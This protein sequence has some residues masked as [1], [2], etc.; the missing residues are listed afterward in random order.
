MSFDAF[1][2]AWKALKSTIQAHPH[3]PKGLSI[4][5]LNFLTDLLLVQDLI[6]WNDPIFTLQLTLIVNLSCYLLT[7]ANY[8]LLSYCSYVLMFLMIISKILWKTTGK[9][10]L[11]GLHLFVKTHFFLGPIAISVN[12]YLLIRWH[13]VECWQVSQQFSGIYLYRSLNSN[14][15]GIYSIFTLLRLFFPTFVLL[16]FFCFYSLFPFGFSLRF[17]ILSRCLC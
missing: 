17:L 2:D 7:Y 10:L 5:K 12:T 15:Q 1:T 16:D 13:T 3:Y 9:D 8:T 4:L 11:Y 6:Y 14:I